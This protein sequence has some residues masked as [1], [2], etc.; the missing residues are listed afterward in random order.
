MPVPAGAAQLRADVV[1]TAP[2]VG[3][4]L[5]FIEADN[6]T[7]DAALK[8]AKF[9]KY[10]RFCKRRRTPTESRRCDA[11]AGPCPTLSRT[12]ACIR[13]SCSLSH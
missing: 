6:Y 9:G 1:L 3:V 11:P 13:R 5:L 12:N 7:E 2:E 8:A 10:A 4:P